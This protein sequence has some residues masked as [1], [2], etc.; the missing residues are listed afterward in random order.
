MENSVHCSVEGIKHFG[1]KTW[2]NQV[3]GDQE[4]SP[5]WLVFTVQ[6]CAIRLLRGGEV[7]NNPTQLTL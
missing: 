4:A 2:R 6:K 3:V 1:H 5:C 7:S